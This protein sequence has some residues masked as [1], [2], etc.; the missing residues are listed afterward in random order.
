[1]SMKFEIEIAHPEKDVMLTV[2]GDYIPSRSATQMEP[3]EPS[4]VE[5]LSIKDETGTELP[6]DEFENLCLSDWYEGVL[7]RA[8]QATWESQY[9]YIC[10]R[11]EYEYD[12]RREDALLGDDR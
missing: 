6:G 9:E 1:M 10:A 5:I 2:A 4:S 3:G 12:R 7:D 11:A 8:E